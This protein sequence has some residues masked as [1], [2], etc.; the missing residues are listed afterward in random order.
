MSN[1]LK[2]RWL[3]LASVAVVALSA[4]LA[5]AGTTAAK[6]AAP[7]SAQA[8]PAPAPAPAKPADASHAAHA[9]VDINTATAEELAKLP[10]IGDAYSQKI[11]AGRP[12]KGKDELLS[13]KVLPKGVYDKIAGMIIAK[14]P[15]H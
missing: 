14:Q 4:S 5:L 10:G 6:P 13:K 12:Y 1:V 9:K 7:A 11:I 8:A 15:A 3:V 2:S